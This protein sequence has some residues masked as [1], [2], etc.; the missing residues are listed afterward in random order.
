[1]AAAAKTASIENI[2]IDS[3][4]Y[5]SAQY[6]VHQKTLSLNDLCPGHQPPRNARSSA[7]CN[8]NIASC[9]YTQ[10]SSN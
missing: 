7:G 10:D 6:T 8:W 2:L 1:M 9:T 3:A 4:Q 5:S